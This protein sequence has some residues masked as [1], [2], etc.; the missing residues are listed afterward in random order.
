MLLKNRPLLTLVL[1][2]IYINA[3][4]TTPKLS[5]DAE[6]SLMTCSPGNEIYTVFGH[7]AIR[8][9]DQKNNIDNTYNYGVF[10]MG[11][12]NFYW[13]FALGKTYYMLQKEP[14][15]GF[16]RVYN[17]YNRGINAATLN[18]NPDEK[19][20]LFEDLE[21]EALPENRTYLYN[22]F[23]NNCSTKAKD[24]ILSVKHSAV[25]YD[26]PLPNKSFRDYINEHTKNTPLY[27]FI[28]SLPLGMETDRI[29]SR[30]ESMFLPA[31]LEKELNNAHYSSDK[32]PIFTNTYTILPSPTP[33]KK[34]SNFSVFN[35]IF[36]GLCLSIPI[37]SLLSKR[38]L[39]FIDYTLLTIF[40]LGGLVLAFLALFSL[41]P[42]VQTN[43]NLLWL[44]PLC[45][46]LIIQLIRNKKA[47][48]TRRLFR[49][50]AL[51]IIIFTL[52]ST[53][54][55]QYAHYLT[56]ILLCCY[57]IRIAC[58]MQKYQR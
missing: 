16:V 1:L 56:M 46:I 54:G 10:S 8:V 32:S 52:L 17:Y 35:L 48:L 14:T 57:L 21:N 26:A 15:A 55:L 5:T 36:I 6:I 24:A 18:L 34:S 43:L 30:E 19:Q 33:T 53:I 22:Y 41:H 27:Q 51:L 40:T 38:S 28:L 31:Y 39:L 11:W 4:S 7:T 47:K 37:V 44:N 12:D 20:K 9:K 50:Y 13:K 23:F 29:A 45:I 2:L 58:M 3:F 49:I 42:C 25:Q